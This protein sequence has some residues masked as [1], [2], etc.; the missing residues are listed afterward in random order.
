[1]TQRKVYP[2]YSWRKPRASVLVLTTTFTMALIIIMWDIYH[3][4]EVHSNSSYDLLGTF[5]NDY[6]LTLT[7]P[8]AV[9]IWKEREFLVIV[10]IPSVDRDEWQKR[11]NLQRR[12]CWQYAGV[13]TLENNFTGELLPLYLL[14]PHQLN[15]YE[16]SESL[17]DEASRTNDVV[18]LPTNDVCSFSRRKIGEGGSWGVE[19]ELVMSRKTF[20][21]LQFAVTA[22]PNV[23]YIVKGDDDVF[24]RVPQYLADLRVMPR[25]GLYM[26]RVYG[27]T[28]FWRSGG[29]PFAAGYFTT[30]SRDVA[31]AVASYRPLER[32]LKAPY[33]IWRMRQYLSMSVLHEDVMTALV[34]QDKIRYKGLIIANA[35]GCHFHNKAKEDI[36]EAVSNRSVVV[37]HIREE[38][39]EVL[40][41]HFS[42]ISERPQPYGVRWLRN[43]RAMVLC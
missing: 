12:T 6:Y 11:R 39:Y 35:A 25:N 42:N 33:S 9:S 28:F 10:G 26:G 17:R 5:E 24:V 31:E 21:W 15:G 41:D 34:L 19:S 23:S 43:D 22:F 38:D 2:P 30:F 14:A 8:S 36:R 37:H 20:L 32:L 13:A 4:S 16:I 7:P 29:I 3:I 40:M 18:M 1:M 27:A